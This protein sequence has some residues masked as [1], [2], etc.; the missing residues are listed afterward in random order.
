MA[1]RRRKPRSQQ[2]FP[3]VVKILQPHDHEYG[4]GARWRVHDF[5]DNVAYFLEKDRMVYVLNLH[6]MMPVPEERM[7]FLRSEQQRTILASL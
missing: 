2:M 5:D 7:S 1:K 4:H 3:C 6:N